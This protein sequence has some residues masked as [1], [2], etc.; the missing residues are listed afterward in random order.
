MERIYRI[1]FTYEYGAIDIYIISAISRYE[2]LSY[3][4]KEL[5]NKIECIQS[6]E[7]L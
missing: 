1:Q 4:L 5:K 2:A 3:F 6:I 7:F